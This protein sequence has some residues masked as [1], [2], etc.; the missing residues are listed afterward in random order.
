MFYETFSVIFIPHDSVLEFVGKNFI[1]MHLFFWP[2]NFGTFWEEER[3]VYF[4][5]KK[6]PDFSHDPFLNTKL[7]GHFQ[8][9]Q[10]I[11]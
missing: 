11:F 10:S 6:P 9:C 7:G 4:S 2:P 8:A 5:L 3:G 1:K